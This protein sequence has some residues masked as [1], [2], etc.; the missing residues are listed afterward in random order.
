MRGDAAVWDERF[1]VLLRARLTAL[2]ADEPLTPT[3]DLR[4]AGLDSLGT[5]ELVV[6]I[7]DEFGVVVPDEALTYET[8]AT[9]GSVWAVVDRA[10]GGAGGRS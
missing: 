1:E 5:M 2:G 10:T 9:A 7:E 8:F 3:T 6:G 4:S